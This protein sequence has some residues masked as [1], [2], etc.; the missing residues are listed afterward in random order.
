M[1]FLVP[2]QTALPLLKALPCVFTP[3]ESPRL[4]TGLE[5][6]P[7]QVPLPPIHPSGIST[8]P[9]LSGPD[10]VLPSGPLH[11][12][13][14]PPGCVFPQRWAGLTSH[15]FQPWLKCCFLPR[16]TLTTSVRVTPP[17]LQD[18][19]FQRESKEYFWPCHNALEHLFVCLL[20]ACLLPP[21]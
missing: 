2:N 21:N 12:P 13:F 16:L 18:S 5:A 3:S 8:S 10:C 6:G 14:P 17:A 15:H 1:I 19:G 11:L 7:A 20:T 4:D 9:P